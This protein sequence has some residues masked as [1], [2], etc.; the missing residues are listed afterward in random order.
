M[1]LYIGY[2]S[3]VSRIAIVFK[4]EQALESRGERLLKHTPALHRILKVSDS[5]SLAWIPGICISDK[6]PGIADTDPAGSGTVL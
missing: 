1:I 4:L 6:F 2:V 5:V 3:D